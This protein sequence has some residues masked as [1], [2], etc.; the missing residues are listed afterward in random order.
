MSFG[1]GWTRT[2]E[3]ED[4]DYG[5][6]TAVIRA[7]G[8]MMATLL[9]TLALVTPVLG[10]GLNCQ[11]QATVGGGSATE[12]ETGEEVLIEGTGFPFNTD[13]FITY[14]V[15]ATVVDSETVT[16]DGTGMFE[17]AVTPQAGQEGLWTVEAEVPK[18]C[19]AT[20]QFLVVAASTPPPTPSP[21]P[22]PTPAGELPDVATTAPGDPSPMMLGGLL[23]L[24]A[25]TWVASR[26]RLARRLR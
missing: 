1:V 19:V 26:A 16:A 7:I 18:Q 3:A 14:L 5:C 23:V 13:V 17:T 8:T 10:G 11:L 6:G 20:T 25:A 2:T 21:T 4:M 15:G 9:L 22:V 24:A 12:V